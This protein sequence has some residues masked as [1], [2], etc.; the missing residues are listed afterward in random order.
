VVLSVAV[1]EGRKRGK[2]CPKPVDNGDFHHS[3]FSCI[4]NG[5]CE[6]LQMVTAFQSVSLCDIGHERPICLKL[7]CIIHSFLLYDISIQQ[8]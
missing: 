7:S 6:E 5:R 1:M 2:N 4:T 3:S 8:N